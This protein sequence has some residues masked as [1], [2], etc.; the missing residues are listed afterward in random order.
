MSCIVSGTQRLKGRKSPLF[1]NFFHL[2]PSVGMYSI[3]FLDEPYT[4]P[5]P[6][7]LKFRSY[8]S[9]R[10]TWSYSLCR[11]DNTYEGSKIFYSAFESCGGQIWLSDLLIS[12]RKIVMTI[13]IV[14]MVMC[15]IWI[16]RHVVA[17]SNITQHGRNKSVIYAQLLGNYSSGWALG[18]CPGGFF[19][20]S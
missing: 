16:N 4:R 3:E 15:I 6:P 19:F 17:T 14:M 12:S 11:F 5:I 8:P 10:I 2:R 9:V 13:V 20:L 7:K 1:P 18:S